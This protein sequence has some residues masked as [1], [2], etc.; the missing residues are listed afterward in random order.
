METKTKNIGG[1]DKDKYHRY[2]RPEFKTKVEKPGTNGV[3]TVIEN[4]SAIAKALQVPPEYPTRFL[5]YELCTQATYE[6][7]AD[8]TCTIIKGKHTVQDLDKALEEFIKKFI[9]CSKC[10]L[11]ETKI[12][13]KKGQV[14]VNCRGCGHAGPLTTGHKLDNYISKNPPSRKKDD[15]FKKSTE[16]KSP[17]E[18]EPEKKDEDEK[19][20]WSLD[21]SIEAQKARR[22]EFLAA[23]RGKTPI[24]PDEET[25]NAKPE[26]ILKNFMQITTDPVAV[27]AELDRLQLKHGLVPEERYRILLMSAI[28]VSSPKTIATQFTK[29]APLLKRVVKDKSGGILLITSIERLLDSASP[30][31]SDSGQEQAEIRSKLQEDLKANF[32]TRIPVILKKLYDEDALSEE[33][34]LAWAQSPPE[35][36]AAVGKDVA[37]YA[38]K[39]AK[40][41]IQWLQTAEEAE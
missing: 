16:E 34:I 1:T 35:A 37:T 29:Q 5:G 20:E 25:E 31:P 19:E 36:S 4:M 8:R 11:P 23:Q 6:D 22:A 26:T 21:T 9:L 28:D 13:V 14:R 40:P 10:K 32:V 30:R 2:K 18:I 27:L 41:F 39:C 7:S 15:G 3:K 12:S 17:T 33:A 24:S 38:R